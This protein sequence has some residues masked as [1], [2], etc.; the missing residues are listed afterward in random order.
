MGLFNKKHNMGELIA[1]LRKV[2]GITQADL[3]EL[4]GV[5]DKAVSKWE[6]GDGNPE[7]SQLPYLARV[8]DITLD[9]LMTG[10]ENDKSFNRYERCARNDELKAFDKIV[11]DGNIGFNDETGNTVIDYVL[12]FKATKI[13]S[14]IIDNGLVK[15]VAKDIYINRIEK[16]HDKI[17]IGKQIVVM[18]LLLGRISEKD[19][20]FEAFEVAQIEGYTFN[21]DTR[22]YSGS[23]K[24]YGPRFNLSCIT[25]EELYNILISVELNNTTKEYLM[26]SELRLDHKGLP[27]IAECINYNE[28][29]DIAFS[30]GNM[31]LI[32]DIV[33]RINS[34]VLSTSL[35]GVNIENVRK[36]YVEGKYEI[37]EMMNG[38]RI[39]SH[40]VKMIKLRSTNTDKKA[41][42]ESDVIV[43]GVL[44]IDRVLIYD[45]FDFYIEMLNKPIT[46]RE[47]KYAKLYKEYSFEKCIQVLKADGYDNSYWT[48]YLGLTED[49]LYYGDEDYDEAKLDELR[50]YYNPESKS[51]EREKEIFAWYITSDTIG[52]GVNRKHKDIYIKKTDTKKEAFDILKDLFACKFTIGSEKNKLTLEKSLKLKDIRF[53]EY[54]C[55][56]SD[57]RG[58]NDALIELVA[59]DN[60]DTAKIK[61]LLEHGARIV[62]Y[63]VSSNPGCY[64]SVNV[65]YNPVKSSAYTNMISK[66]V[67]L[68]ERIKEIEK[69]LKK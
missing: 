32:D 28:I 45:D 40:E 66:Q 21:H 50:R 44:D 39:S 46:D 65:K 35:K 33:S 57:G 52:R 54:V 29:V 51:E 22:Q 53:L 18:I 12:K 11:Q 58:I 55:K 8:F 38:D 42:R 6:R 49:D 34:G 31:K 3:G 19:V 26:T 10:K 24:F 16:G 62:V 17:L 37:A 9:Y 68:E 47:L 63:D 43:N 27:K 2:K 61:L 14:R 64:D 69:L 67:E 7:T 60:R 13:F 20:F 23:S 36:M 41:L 15:Q 4:L 59:E 25:S 30:Q 48:S 1:S 5:S 56:N